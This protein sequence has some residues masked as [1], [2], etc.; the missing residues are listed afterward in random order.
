MC[1]SPHWG[2]VLKGKVAFRFADHEETY[3]AGDAY[4]APPGHSLV[5]YEGGE[6]VEFS[7]VDKLSAT[8]EMAMKNMQAGLMPGPVSG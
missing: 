8:I 2:Y 4:Y 6:V 7:P 3:E 5:F 1:Q